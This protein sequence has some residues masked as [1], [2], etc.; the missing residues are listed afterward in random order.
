M[1]PSLSDDRSS[2]G[3]GAAERGGKKIVKRR[4]LLSGPAASSMPGNRLHVR[5]YTRQAVAVAEVVEQADPRPAPS[6]ALEKSGKL[7]V[8]SS[9]RPPTRMPGH[10]GVSTRLA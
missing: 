5:N 10:G 8:K 6:A 3:S 4:A 7:V 1:K 9:Q 2:S